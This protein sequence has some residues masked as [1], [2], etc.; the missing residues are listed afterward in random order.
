MPLRVFSQRAII[1]LAAALSAASTVARAGDAEPDPGHG[2]AMGTLHRFVD[3]RSSRYP[4][5]GCLDHR[6]LMFIV[7][8]IEGDDPAAARLLVAR[9]C[10]PLVPG[11]DYVRCG[12]GGYAY[13][14]AGDRLSYASY[15]RVGAGDLPLYV[16]DSQMM[17]IDNGGR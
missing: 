14:A 5:A 9:D 6:S 13:P 12:P 2:P 15:C 1:A 7:R 10:R 8:E 11:A 4:A 16:L 3:D 17:E